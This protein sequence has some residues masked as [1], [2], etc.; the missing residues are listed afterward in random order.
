MSTP[1]TPPI[2]N[3]T[4]KHINQ[5]IGAVNLILP[6]YIVKSQLNIST[7]VGMA[8][9]MV[10]IPLNALTFAPAPMVKK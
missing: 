5:I 10:V 7:P 8:M 9:I 1:V 6:L 4:A 2:V 3:V